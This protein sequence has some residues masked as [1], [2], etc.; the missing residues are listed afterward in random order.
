V[1][2]CHITSQV[3]TDPYQKLLSEKGGRGFPHL[4][5]MDAEGT[6]LAS[7]AD[8]TVASFMKTN[9][10]LKR[11]A[12]LQGKTDPASVTALVFA[13]LDMGMMKA[14]DAK[15]KLSGMTLTPAQVATLESAMIDDEVNAAR[16]NVRTRDEMLAVGDTYLEMK[17]KGR[18]PT[19]KSAPMFWGTIATTAESKKDVALF[20][21]CV[22]QMKKIAAADPRYARQVDAMETRLKSMK[23]PK[24]AAPEKQAKRLGGG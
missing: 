2:F 22:T 19:G 14:A 18:V 13:K 6:V 23:D 7:P 11:I 5:F 15:E 20:E 4:V 9:T 24:G 1:L 3:S 16:A 21:E 17:A 10:E 8:R 12:D